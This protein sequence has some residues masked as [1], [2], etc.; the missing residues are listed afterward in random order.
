MGA[1]NR[2]AMSAGIWAPSIRW[3]CVA[4]MGAAALVGYTRCCWAPRS[5]W[6]YVVLVGAATGLAMRSNLRR[7]VR[8]GYTGHG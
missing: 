7:R 3:L 5:L 6:I 8:V 2:V 4:Q 1:V